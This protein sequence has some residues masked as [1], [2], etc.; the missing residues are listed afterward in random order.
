[1][2][3]HKLE[4][5]E[6]ERK[7]FRATF[8]RYGSKPAFRGPA[9]RT[10]LLKDVTDVATGAIA[11]DHLWFNLT[12]GFE[13]V[14]PIHGDVIEFDARVKGYSKGYRGHR[15]DVYNPPSWDYKLS[16]PTRIRLIEAGEKRKRQHFLITGRLYRSPVGEPNGGVK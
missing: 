8:E 9:Q 14:N 13:A 1:V 2:T 4:K 7:R 6:G 11:T 10:V 3:R 5:V 12:K 16:H 15:E